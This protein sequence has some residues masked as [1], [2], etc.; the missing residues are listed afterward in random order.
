[1][2]ETWAPIAVMLLGAV[3]FLVSIRA[4]QLLSLNSTYEDQIRELRAACDILRSQFKTCTSNNADLANKLLAANGEIEPLKTERDRLADDCAELNAKLNLTEIGRVEYRDKINAKTEECR[5]LTSRLDQSVRERGDIVAANT[6]LHAEIRDYKN[7]ADTMAAMC[8]EALDRNEELM[9]EVGQLK[10][11]IDA[12]DETIRNLTWD[13]ES[14][15]GLVA[16][17]DEH[18]AALEATEGKLRATIGERNASLIECCLHV[19][20]LAKSLN[21][22]H[23]EPTTEESN[24]NG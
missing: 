10:A 11:K 18:I 16:A 1:M 2:I 6:K 9:A 13:N 23:T 5:S 17:K 4:S 22:W 20:N 21:K 19:D 14:L 8:Q 12:A 24:A 3:L 7:A 15:V